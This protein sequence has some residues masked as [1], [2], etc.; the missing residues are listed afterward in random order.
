MVVRQRRAGGNCREAWRKRSI[1]GLAAGLLSRRSYVSESVGW[2]S[3]RGTNAR[4]TVSRDAEPPSHVSQREACCR[5]GSTEELG[6]GAL[7]ESVGETALQCRCRVA[8][9]APHGG[10]VARDDAGLDLH[11]G[12]RRQERLESGAGWSVSRTGRFFGLMQVLPWSVP[13]L[14]LFKPKLCTRAR[15][16]PVPVRSPKAAD[17]ARVELAYQLQLR[18]GCVGTQRNVAAWP[19]STVGATCVLSLHQR[20]WGRPRSSKSRS[21]GFSGNCARAL[22]GCAAVGRLSSIA[23]AASRGARSRRQREPRRTRR[24]RFSRTG[25]RPHGQPR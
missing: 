13:P 22:L 5:A 19:L 8:F 21:S 1:A 7:E 3:S 2:S 6:E 4:R 15:T 17:C 25:A 9:C 14:P 20:S 23:G 11:V 12:E 24:A 18:H 10:S 16:T